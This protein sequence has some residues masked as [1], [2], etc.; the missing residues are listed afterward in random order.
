MVAFIEL[1]MMSILL[2]KSSALPVSVTHNKMYHGT[3]TRYVFEKVRGTLLMFMLR[4][5]IS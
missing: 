1:P 2:F 4:I 5:Y 3:V